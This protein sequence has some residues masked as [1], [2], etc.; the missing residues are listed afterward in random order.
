MTDTAPPLHQ[1]PRDRERLRP[2]A[3]PRRARR[4]LTAEQ[5]RL[6]ADRRAGIGGDGVIRVVP[7]AGRRRGA[8]CARRP[9]TR[10]G[11]WTT[12]TPT[13]A[14]PRCAATAPGSSRRTC[15]ARGSRPPTSSPSRPAPASSWSGFEDGLIAVNLGAVAAQ[16][17]RRRADADGFDALVKVAGHDP[18][19]GAQPRPRQPAHRRRAAR[20]RPTSPGSTSPGARRSTRSRRTGTNVEFVRPLGAGHLSMRV[21]ERGVGETRSCGTGAAAAAL[22]TRWWAGESADADVGAS[23]S[24]AAPCASGRCPASRSS[25]PARRSSSPTG[26]PP[27]SEQPRRFRVAGSRSPA[28][29]PRPWAT[30]VAYFAGPSSRAWPSPAWPFRSLSRARRRRPAPRAAATTTTA[31]R[32]PPQHAAQGPGD[33]RQRWRRRLGRP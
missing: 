21:H 14:S 2:R 18:M 6:L 28:Y 19:P 9:P 8:R 10:G 15:G 22:A 3:R 11:S 24:R 7:T 26:P 30:T 31:A 23:T 32:A 27:S 13:A 12:A 25:S 29:R 17:P 33:D 20:A 4:D 5:V 16:R 1:G